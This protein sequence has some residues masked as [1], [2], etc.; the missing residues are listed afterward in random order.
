MR[1]GLVSLALYVSEFGRDLFIS[2]A[3]YLKPPVSNFRVLLLLFMLS[4]QAYMAYVY[5]SALAGSLERSIGGFNLLQGNFSVSFG[6]FL[7]VL[8]VVGPLGLLN[9]FALVLVAIY[10]GYRWLTE[11]DIWAALRVPPNEF[12]EDDM[13]AMEKAVE[14]AIR[15]SLTELRLN[16]EDLRM[17]TADRGGQIF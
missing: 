4:F 6:E 7:R 13:M 10:S 1:R 3:S 17:A 5:P 9:M 14:E 11:R 12:N 15:E 8:C 16:P 2:M